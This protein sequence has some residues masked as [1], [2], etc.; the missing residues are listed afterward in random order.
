[1]FRLI[2]T[3]KQILRGKF[4]RSVFIV[5][6]GTASAQL[7]NSILSPIITRIY[8]P[9][10]FGVLAGYISIVGL[11]SIVGE[12]QAINVLALSLFVLSIVSASSLLF[13]VF[14]GSRLEK[15]FG[16]SIPYEY[17]LLIP[18]GLFTSSLYGIMRQWSL[19]RKDFKTLA[20]TQITQSIFGNAVKLGLGILS[21]GPIGLILGTVVGSSMGVSSLARPV[22]VKDRHLLSQIDIKKIRICAKRYVK[23]PIFSFPG[24]FL[25]AAGNNLPVLFIGGLFGQ[26]TLGYYALANSI[27]RL[28][29]YLIGESVAQVFYAELARI[30][31][32]DPVGT[33]NMALNL[34]KKLSIIGLIPVLLLLPFGPFLFSFVFGE[35]WHLSGVYA[36][37]ISFAVYAN[38]IIAPVGRIME[39]FERQGIGFL[40]NCLRL[41]MVLG[42]FFAA[43]STDLGSY[44]TIGLYVFSI[45]LSYSAA[46]ICVIRMLNSEIAK[47][48]NGSVSRTNT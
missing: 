38:F 22:I 16:S 47:Q 41:A 33:K 25:Y 42:V 26:E 9:E 29:L 20:R 48:S 19:R 13:V 18:L 1:M 15:I 4:G 36:R 2:S 17:S 34:M 7:I 31:K 27:V 40:L 10:E 39:V 32:R 24:E 35:G 44:I 8:N 14:F 12:E 21:L 23:F 6:G 43:Y 28:P 45:V 37:I 5:A 3:A 11:L 46:L 30:G